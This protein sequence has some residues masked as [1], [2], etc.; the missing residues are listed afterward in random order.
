MLYIDL[1]KNKEDFI[2][3]DEEKF[4]I[5]IRFQNSVKYLKLMLQKMFVLLMN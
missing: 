3:D 2:L 1:A 5:N 4:P